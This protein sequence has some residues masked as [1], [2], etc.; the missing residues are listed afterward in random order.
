MERNSSTRP[1]FDDADA[2]VIFRSSD[3][4]EFRLYKNAIAKASPVFRDMFTLPDGPALTTEPQVVPLTEDADTLERLFRLCYP[5]ERPR[6]ASL[7][8]TRLAAPHV[9]GH[10]LWPRGQIGSKKSKVQ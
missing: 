4:V 6:F 9:G 7:E 3:G 5:V 10:A 2:D 8:E 1:P